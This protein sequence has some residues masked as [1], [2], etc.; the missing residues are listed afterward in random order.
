MR[1]LV[2]GIQ[3]LVFR[4]EISTKGGIVNTTPFSKYII[5]N[6]LVFTS[7]Q[8]H[9][10]VD[11]ALVEGTIEEKTHQVMKNLEK[12]LHEAGVV[13]DD[14]VKTTIYVTNMSNYAH[15]NQVYVSYFH[16]RMPARELVCVKELPLGA[17]IE[18]S[19]IA[20]KI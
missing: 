8:V 11:G 17:E 4:I 3:Y 10:G 12:I 7:G 15:I 1:S 13:F 16:D 19:M 18:M 9:L 6:N 5:T 14:V 20:E 2:C